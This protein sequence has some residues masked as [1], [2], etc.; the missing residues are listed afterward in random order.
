MLISG[1]RVSRPPFY[2]KSKTDFSSHTTNILLSANHPSSGNEAGN[3]LDLN[4][5]LPFVTLELQ[6]GSQDETVIFTMWS[7]KIR[8]T[9]YEKLKFRSHMKNLQ[10]LEKLLKPQ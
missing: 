1:K 2:S 5:V 4:C 3:G 8:P 6:R 10:K 9:H 7:Y